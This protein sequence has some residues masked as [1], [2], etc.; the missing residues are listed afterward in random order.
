[1]VRLITTI[2]S[3]LTKKQRVTFATRRGKAKPP[4]QRAHVVTAAEKDSSPEEDEC[5]LFHIEH[6]QSKTK[7]LL[8]T[9]T[10]EG[11]PVEM[12][13]DTG[14]DVSIMAERTYQQLFSHKPLQPSTVRLN[15]YTQSP[16]L[17]K[18]QLP[19]QVYYGQQTFQLT[20]SVD[21]FSCGN[22]WNTVFLYTETFT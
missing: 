17:V 16:I 4:P 20:L 3:V 8:C 19:V 6:K 18:G 12:E 10:I 15:T 5:H 21:T 2:P 14:A 13:I 11:K 22:H 1:M 7:A 9:L